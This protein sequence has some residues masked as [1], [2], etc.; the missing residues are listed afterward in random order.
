[1]DLKQSLNKIN[2]LFESK[3]KETVF[4]DLGA[5]YIKGVTKEQKTIKNVFI[6][7]ATSDHAKDIVN[8]LK[9]YHLL[10]AGVNLCIKSPDAI[11]RY[12]PFPRMEKKGLKQSFSFE[13]SKHIPFPAETVYFDV[14]VIEEEFSKTESLVLLAAV[15]KD[16]LT[17]IIEE[18]AKEKINISTITLSPLS[19]INVFLSWQTPADNCA[20]IDIGYGSTSL[21]LIRKTMPYLSREIKISGKSLLKKIS[22]IK[23]CDSTEAEKILVAQQNPAE[24]A[25]INEEIFLGIAEEIRSS[26]DYF[27]MNTGEQINTLYLTGGFSYLPGADTL[28]AN[29]LGL[30]AKPWKPWEK[31]NIPLPDKSLPPDM[32]SAVMGLV[33]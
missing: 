18:A 3:E 29:S 23:S 24:I 1:M 11:M 8:I 4:L 26:L 19:L 33:L 6:E 13:L 21:S 31:L 28:L 17:P 5:R 2:S 25:E 20:I 32:F 12:I 10:S 30:E 9:K 7:E 16:V 22:S 15:K 14:C 27:E